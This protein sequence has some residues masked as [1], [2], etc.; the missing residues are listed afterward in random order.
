[1][2]LVF[3]QKISISNTSHISQYFQKGLALLSASLLSDLSLQHFY[4]GIGLLSSG[5][6]LKRVDKKR[7]FRVSCLQASFLD[8]LPRKLCMEHRQCS[9]CY[10]Q[11]VAVNITYQQNLIQ[12]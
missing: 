2:F 1:M 6:G 9:R 10:V 5:L 8:S 4:R 11:Q 12:R 3:R 7:D